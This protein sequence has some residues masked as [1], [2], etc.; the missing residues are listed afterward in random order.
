M[1]VAQL[2]QYNDKDAK[3]LLKI[4]SNIVNNPQKAEYRDLNLNRVKQKTNNWMLCEKIL[5]FSGF[6]VS[7]NDIRLI[8]PPNKLDKLKDV[9]Q[10][11]SSLVDKL[12]QLLSMG[13]DR[14]TSALALSVCNNDMEMAVQY[15]LGCNQAQTLHYCEEKECDNCLIKTCKHLHR[16]HNMMTKYQQKFS[17]DDNIDIVTMLNDFNH[18]LFTHNN[19]QDFEYIYNLFPSC[20]ASKCYI[21]NRHYRDR[22][23]DSKHLYKNK[24][25]SEYDQ[26]FDKVH[27]HFLHSYDIGYRLML[28][29]WQQLQIIDEEE[30]TYNVSHLNTKLIKMKQM[31][32]DQHRLH[33]KISHNNSWKKFNQIQQNSVI[34]F[35][36]FSFGELFYY[37][38]EYNITARDQMHRG[39]LYRDWYIK[40]K[41]KSLKEEV[42]NSNINIDQ[43]T[44]EIHKAKLHQQTRFCKKELLANTSMIKTLHSTSSYGIQ[45][46]SPITVNHLVCVIIYCAYTNFSYQFSKTFR[47]LDDNDKNDKLQNN[48]YSL[49]SGSLRTTLSESD[50]LLKKR[51]SNFAH[52][53][54]YLVETVKLFSVGV[55]DKITTLYHGI[56]RE[57]V[58]DSMACAMFQPLSTTSEW[59]VA[60]QFSTNKG[61]VIEFQVDAFMSHFQCNWISDFSNENESLIIHAK[62][63]NITN[64]VNI[65]QYLVEDFRIPIE[66]ISII[67][68]VIQGSAFCGNPQ[69]INNAI[70]LRAS[71][72]EGLV[73][74]IDEDDATDTKYCGGEEMN[75]ALKSLTIKFIKHELNRYKPSNYPKYTK[76]TGS[77]SETLLHQMCIKVD[78]VIINWKYMNV[79]ILPKLEHSGYQCY[80]FLKQL[81]CVHECSM[82]NLE[83][84]SLLF[85]NANSIILE[86]LPQVSLDCL[87]YNLKWLLANNTNII[88]V[89]LH[90]LKDSELSNKK[91]TLM[92][93]QQ[94][95]DIGW[96]IYENEPMSDHIN[97]LKLETQYAEYY[98][99]SIE[100]AGAHWW[101]ISLRN[102]TCT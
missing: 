81:L 74:H 27:C 73:Q 80:A 25:R 30:D 21:I 17:Y 37:W 88:A 20:I 39:Y 52:F 11:L 56:D 64:I 23:I 6:Y 41:Y 75:P 2:I 58:F 59:E 70:D 16:L 3:L 4:L 57:M 102:M 92:Y 32:T 94:F 95:E 67:E 44:S 50:H 72:T 29:D 65:Q 24:H 34:K 96:D 90:A 33:A 31:M 87:Q 38:R 89:E 79:N 28:Q 10:L 69:V 14:Q 42:T 77:Y 47:R 12:H 22:S 98:L 43:W 45:D 68:H 19:N 99:N 35:P 8:L 66:V 62:S 1:N 55:Y 85:P 78:R 91:L 86:D 46:G 82:I 100:Y 93:K 49:Q 7:S 53:A 15:I 61:M 63:L 54:K 60:L 97:K 40:S 83:L 9:H 71:I 26:M 76:I 36:N 51:H 18:M 13:F 48:R 84:I 101:S 5:L